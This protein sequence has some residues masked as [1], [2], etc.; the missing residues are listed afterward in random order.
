MGVDQLM[1]SLQDLSMAFC[2]VKAVTST[3]TSILTAFCIRLLLQMSI[4]SDLK[5][6]E[7]VTLPISFPQANLI[8]LL[9]EIPL[10]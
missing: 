4:W 6:L 9:P 7:E 1:L 3:K 8:T 10:P 2:K 5:G